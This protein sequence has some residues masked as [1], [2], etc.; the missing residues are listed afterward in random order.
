MEDIE[1]NKYGEKLPPKNNKIALID[2]DTIAF[3]ACSNTEVQIDEEQWEPNLSAAMIEA[4]NKIEKILEQTGCQQLE[5]HFSDS[6][7]C[8]RY[9][10]QSDGTLDWSKRNEYKANRK[11]MRAPAGLIELKKMLHKKYK[12][13]IST[14]WEADDEVIFRYKQNPEKY[15]LVAIDKDVLNSVEG[16]HF[17]YYESMKYNKDMKWV[18]TDSYTAF[19]W[20][21]VQALTGDTSDN[22]KGVKGIGPAKA[23]KILRGCFTPNDAWVAVVDAYKKA[24][25]TEEN[26]VATYNMVSMHLLTKDG[27]KIK[28]IK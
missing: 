10:I 6:R 1:V 18:E 12:G 5:L 4:E 27:I 9:Y 13:T 17:N 7:E 22:V 26:A 11:D 3:I 20:P 23:N 24:G 14:K 19:I 8:F 28:E 16:N 2:A 21:Y 15:I 25:M